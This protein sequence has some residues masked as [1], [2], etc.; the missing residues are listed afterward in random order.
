MTNTFATATTA[1]PHDVASDVETGSTIRI[2][3]GHDVLEG[4]RR[5][6]TTP[7]ATEPLRK[8]A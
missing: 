6:S 5:R 8:S 7:A 1:E 3:A 2:D 4:P